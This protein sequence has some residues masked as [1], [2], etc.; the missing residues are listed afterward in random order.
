MGKGVTG[1]MVSPVRSAL[2]LLLLIL[3]DSGCRAQFET[4]NTE[5]AALARALPHLEIRTTNAGSPFFVTETP[6][7]TTQLSYN[8]P[9]EARTLAAGSGYHS[10]IEEY[11]GNSADS[12]DF[13][14]RSLSILAYT[15][16]HTG[17]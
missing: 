16:D 6:V 3:S 17:V 14:G 9:G 15:G 11:K 12:K 7:L 4:C 10:I 8:R 2:L 5:L 13:L 1:Q